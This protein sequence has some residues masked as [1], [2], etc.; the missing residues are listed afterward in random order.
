MRSLW[1]NRIGRRLT[2][3]AMALVVT[4]AFAFVA[5]HVTP[6]ASADAFTGCRGKV[7]QSA[8]AGGG[9]YNLTVSLV[10]QFGVGGEFGTGYCGSMK[11]TATMSVPASG[12][13]GGLT[14][15]LVGS[16]GTSLSNSYTFPDA[17]PSGGYSFTE[18]SPSGGPKCAY[19]T[20]T[21]TATTGQVFTATTKSSCPH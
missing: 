6:K 3:A 17:S 19:S 11:T 10:A 7:L 12:A 2:L 20:A 9:G 15:T 1:Q 16:D 8:T 18:N 13:G 14:V 4:L 5:T 21:F